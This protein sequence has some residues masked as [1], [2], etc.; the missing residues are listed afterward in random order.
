MARAC[1]HRRA[2]DLFLVHQGTDSSESAGLATITSAIQLVQASLALTALAGFVGAPLSMFI[3]P[4]VVLLVDGDRLGG[5]GGLRAI[6]KFL[7]KGGRLAIALG[8][9]VTSIVAV[10][11]AT[12]VAVATR[13]ATLIA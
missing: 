5:I 13:V 8:I 3:A 11:I 9:A 1:L 12:V 4:V 6:I 7:W 10:G 2:E